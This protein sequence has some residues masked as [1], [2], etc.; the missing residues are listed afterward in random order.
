MS[1][2]ILDQALLADAAD[3]AVRYLE[4]LPKRAVGPD[5]SSVARLREELA[6]P[7][8]EQSCDF[9]SV[10]DALDEFGSPATMASAGPRFFGFVHGG[11]LPV[12]LAA[13]WLASAWDQ[14]A[15]SFT[16]SPVGVVVEE[17]AL[18]WMGSLFGLPET[19]AAA[20]TTG[21]TM[22]NFTALAAARHRLLARLDW[23]VESQ[24]LF[25]APDIRVVVSAESHP[26]VGKALM[27]LGLGRDR[28]IKAPVDREGRIRVDAIPDLDSRTLVCS[29]AGNVN[30]GAFDPFPELVSACR[31]AGAWLHV[32][33]A[34]GLWALASAEKRSL[35]VGIEGA[36]SWVTDGH[37][38]LNVPYDSG[39]AFV[40]DAAA[41]RSAMSIEAPYLPVGAPREPFHYTPETSRRARGIEI[42]AALRGLGREGVEAMIDRSCRHASRFAEVLSTEGYSVLND[43]VLNQVV[44]SFGEDELNR[45]VVESVQNDGVC[46]C[47]PTLWQ[48]R[49]AMRISV[50]GWATCEQDVE[51]SL[52][53]ILRCAQ[54]SRPEV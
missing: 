21:A 9:G 14:N 11:A 1:E 17:T 49:S 24:G 46:W 37:K 42:W 12:A 25:G 19:V 13:N 23:D 26:T 48:G 3:R 36:D 20:I 38:W 6:G 5:L 8:P 45:K 29:Q 31:A 22:A 2:T 54:R 15:F 43:V 33:G 39:V 10:L 47:G 18:R 41:L 28:V 40:R 50:S 51:D 4:A 52:E 7:M 53:S 30:S 34:F 32:D 35:A 44:V 16:S 27:M